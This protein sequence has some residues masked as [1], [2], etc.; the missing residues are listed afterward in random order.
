MA[1]R[2][3]IESIDI[4]KG[5]GMLLIVYGHAKFTPYTIPGQ[6]ICSFHVP[7][8]FFLSGFFVPNKGNFKKNLFYI[9]KILLVPFLFFRTI[10]IITR[11]FVTHPVIDQALFYEIIFEDWEVFALWFIPVLYLAIIINLLIRKIPNLVFQYSVILFLLLSGAYF[12]LYPVEYNNY[13]WTCALSAA[14]YYYMGTIYWKNHK[15][16]NDQNKWWSFLLLIVLLL[17]FTFLNTPVLYYINNLGNPLYAYIAAI[18]GSFLTLLIAKKIEVYCPDWIISIFT[19]IGR[20][21]LVILAFHQPILHYIC[22]LIVNI[23]VPNMI[24]RGV[25]WLL[26]IILIYVINNYFPFML[27][28]SKKKKMSYK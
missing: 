24:A 17:L 6:I 3:R 15:N 7:L 2:K 13:N 12:S 23:G 14:A 27:G 16:N 22:P 19:Y 18:A 4:A 28:L 26:L 1:D 21:T 11:I 20:N 5:I 9:S 8:F 25:M 10:N